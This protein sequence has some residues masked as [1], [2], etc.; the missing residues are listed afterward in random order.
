MIREQLYIVIDPSGKLV[1]GSAA[2]SRNAAIDRAV[3]FL[4]ARWG[5]LHA[6][7]YRV[8]LASLTLTIC[9][10]QSEYDDL[11]VHG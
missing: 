3:F 10:N 11:G 1:T 4:R 2:L 8:A 7:G 5:L 9:H 6:E